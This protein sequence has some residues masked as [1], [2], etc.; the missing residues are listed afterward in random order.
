MRCRSVK[1]RAGFDINTL[2]PIDNVHEA[3]TPALFGLAVDDTFVRPVHTERLHAAY[4]GDKDIIRFQGNHNSKRPR[5]FYD[6]AS[7]FLQRVLQV[8]GHASPT[9]HP[10]T[11]T[12]VPP[13]PAARNGARCF[14][15]IATSVTHGDLP[16][17]TWTSQYPVAVS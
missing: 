15:M 3:F 4:A 14:G 10:V 6:A 9:S 17:P 2:S 12:A 8:P 5:L 13:P 11:T 16:L 1:K 7:C